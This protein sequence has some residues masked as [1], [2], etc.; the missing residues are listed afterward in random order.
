MENLQEFA[1]FTA[2][3]IGGYFVACGFI[4]SLYLRGALFSLFFDIFR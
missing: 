3:T 2:G 1:A 4:L